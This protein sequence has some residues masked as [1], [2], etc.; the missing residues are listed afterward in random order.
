MNKLADFMNS[1]AFSDGVAKV[2]GDFADFTYGLVLVSNDVDNFVA[3]V[4]K[5]LNQI[6]IDFDPQEWGD[7][8]WRV[9]LPYAW[10]RGLQE[11]GNE[12][13]AESFNPGRPKTGGYRYKGT[14]GTGTE[15]DTY[16]GPK[17]KTVAEQQADV[18][19]AIADA[20]A[21]LR[22]AQA[23]YNEAALESQAKY[24]E[25]AQEAAADYAATAKDLAQKRNEDMGKLNAEH[26]KAV[27]NIQKDFS[28]RLA[29]IV[30]QSM[31]RLRDAFKS[32]TEINLGD[33]FKTAGSSLDGLLAAMK[34]KLSKAKELSKNAALLAGAGFSQTFI[35]QI[36]SQGGDAGNQMAQ[37]ILAATPEAQKQLQD[38]F[39]ESENTSNYGMDALAKSIYEKSGLATNEL[40]SLYTQTQSDLVVALADQQAA[41]EASIVDIQVAFDKGM[42]DAAAR[43]NE[44]IAAAQKDLTAALASSAKSLSD[45]LIDVE[46]DF[47]QKIGSMKGK[48]GGLSK[49]I[50]KARTAISGAQ[51]AV[52]AASAATGAILSG[53][54]VTATG[55]TQPV[56]INSSVTANTNASP[57][58]IQQASINGIK[59]NLP[60][61]LAVV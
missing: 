14:T 61:V 57:D 16:T 10:V 22:D 26:A 3:D 7:K 4:N 50:I 56:V 59:Y 58:Q 51:K 6:G 36:V 42:A 28:N 52:P 29:T 1:D 11:K 21:S 37:S 2:A 38:L 12:A 34:D 46:K 53:G 48:L 20:N 54:A 23:R 5:S 47:N 41:Y 45:S 60:Y 13:L 31:N 24:N 9:W 15:T 49:D 40:R 27:V 32:A 8:I 25:A 19:K 18:K 30:Q 55:I 44:A 35:E 33:M 43:R 17:G 39:I